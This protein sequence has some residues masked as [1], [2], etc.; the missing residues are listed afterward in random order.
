MKRIFAGALL[1]CALTPVV[2]AQTNESMSVLP[3]RV[4]THPIR[5]ARC[6]TTALSPDGKGSFDFIA[7]FYN[8]K[9]SRQDAS[10]LPEWVVANLATGRTKTMRLPGFANSN[11]SVKTQ[12]RAANGRIFFSA[13]GNW[14][15]Y[16]DPS[17]RSVNTLGQLIEADS[18][19]RYQFFYRLVF[20]PDGKLYAATQS[21]NGKVAIAQIDPDTLKWQV[22][23]D[24]G[25]TDR[26]EALTYGYYLAADP[27]WVYV[28]VGK[29]EWRLVGLNIQTGEQRVLSDVVQWVELQTQAAGVRASFTLKPDPSYDLAGKDMVYEQN[30]LHL[31]DGRRKQIWWCQDGK[32]YP[33]VEGG[34]PQVLPGKLL[35]ERFNRTANTKIEFPEVKLEKPSAD[36]S[37]PLRYKFAGA[38]TWQTHTLKIDTVEPIQ[39]ESFHALPDGRLLGNSV[40]YNGFYLF[41]PTTSALQTSGRHGPSRPR[42]A[43]FGDKVY[44]AGYPNCVLHI[45]D[46]GK[47]W[48]NGQNPRQLGYFGS[49]SRAHYAYKLI[50]ASNGRLYNLGRCERG[51]TGSGVAYYDTKDQSFHGHNDNLNFLK[52]RGMVV[53]ES[54]GCVVVSGELQDDPNASEPKPTTAQLVVFD[55]DLKELK[56]ITVRKQL[57]STGWLYAAPNPEQVIGCIQHDDIN[58]IYRF[59]IANE[60]LLAFEQQSVPIDELFIRPSDQ[61]WWVRRSDNILC[62]LDPQT[63]A[64]TVIGRME[65]S[66]SRLTW[67]RDT[68][69]GYSHSALVRV[70]LPSSD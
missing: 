25:S 47:P 63:L 66:V 36:N 58:S 11:Y 23:Q 50:P 12:L 42:M 37:I 38:S 49:K 34:N 17:T 15:H 39:L 41:D 16:Y 43:D 59:D 46:A 21:N 62:R 64:L 69:Y 40:Q 13:Y 6:W 27:P 18:R 51:V 70:S 54:I 19:I 31:K 48:Q 1:F 32:L 68:L 52:P 4:L 20:G 8:Y 53:L 56:R 28:A 61:S 65:S 67:Q 30:T 24:I 22:W 5:S 9:Y 14:I 29:G 55:M 57:P 35:S 26:A 10:V 2:H 3:V 44:F 60:K 45:Y 7:Q 33:A